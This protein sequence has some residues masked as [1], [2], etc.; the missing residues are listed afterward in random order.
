MRVLALL[1][2]ALFASAM[3]L[4]GQTQSIQ[5]EMKLLRVYQ[6]YPH[7]DPNGPDIT[8]KAR[9][10]I[11]G[12]GP[13]PIAG[14]TGQ[15]H[16]PNLQTV[17]WFDAGAQTIASGTMTYTAANT[18]NLCSDNISVNMELEG[19]EED[20][21]T[22]F[23][24]R[25]LCD[26]HRFGAAANG[27]GNARLAQGSGVTRVFQ[28]LNFSPNIQNR[29]YGFEVSLTYTLTN[30]IR[31]VVYAGNAQGGPVADVCEGGNYFVYARTGPGFSGGDFEFQRSDNN[32]A[33]W[34]TVQTGASPAY[35]VTA[36]ANPS[37]LYRVRLRGGFGCLGYANNEGWV[38]PAG[39]GN[40]RVIPTFNAAD[41]NYTIQS[42][43]EGDALSNIT[44][45]SINNLPPNTS[46]TMQLSAPD[47][48]FFVSP[49]PG[50]VS[51]PYTWQ[52]LEPG[53]YRLN[54][55]GVLINGE[56]LPTGQ[57]T[58]DIFIQ[59][60]PVT[61]PAFT[62]LIPA[63]PGC[64]ET[65][66]SV[67]AIISTYNAG[68]VH[69][70]Q[71]FAVGNTTT[72]VAT[73]NQQASSA[74]FSNLPPGDY[75]VRLTLNGTCVVN[76]GTFTIA[77]PPA[78]ASGTAQVVYPGAA[79]TVLCP[80]GKTTGNFSVAA[81]TGQNSVQ[82]YLATAL[83]NPLASG[84]ASPGSPFST[85][86]IPGNYT[87]VFQRAD[88]GCQEFE[89]FTIL[90]S[91]NALLVSVAATTKPPACTPLGG[92]LTL[93]V[94][95][96]T[97]PYTFKINGVVRT[98]TSTTGNNRLFNQLPSGRGIY[99]VTDA[100]GCNVGVQRF[101]V[102]AWV[103]GAPILE[104][105]PFVWPQNVVDVMTCNGGNDG[106]FWYEPVGGTGPFQAR[107]APL[108]AN[109][110]PAVAGTAPQIRENLP[111]GVY[112]VYMRDAANCE[113]AQVAYIEEFPAITIT[114]VVPAP[115]YCG[116]TH[117]T[118]KIYATGLLRRTIA[119][120]TW[121]QGINWSLN[122]A[123]GL[124]YSGSNMAED[125]A[126]PN[127]VIIT[128]NNISPQ[129]YQIIIR[130]QKGPA[131][132]SGGYA[133]A[134]AT[135]CFSPVFPLTAAD[136]NV[137]T[138]V[139]VTTQLVSPTCN[140]ETNGRITVNFT[141]GNPGYELT[142]VRFNSASPHPNPTVVET[143]VLASNAPGT[144]TFTNLP[145]GSYGVQVRTAIVDGGASNLPGS[146]T[147]YFPGNWNTSF[148]APYTLANP[149]A[150][151]INTISTVT[152]LQCDLTGGQITVQSV[153]GGT[154]PYRY[155]VNGVDFSTNNLLPALSQ[156]TVY[157]RD[158]N[159]CQA[160]RSY[161]VTAVV[162]P[163]LALSFAATPPANCG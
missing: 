100:N 145:P 106:Y 62:G 45:S 148:F 142:L 36:T 53:R 101:T 81:G 15:I 159:S 122:G 147:S 40:L 41:V 43:C 95:G 103:S 80:D 94:T 136:F 96:G 50:L 112:T 69:S 6:N 7:D 25:N 116:Q 67:T 18:F 161:A 57:C 157:V 27:V 28:L 89:N 125:P 120:L 118:M 131:Y 21:D 30:G 90:N 22:L 37:V 1:L 72:P 54:V 60:A 74:P 55:T 163:S 146:C 77:A 153:S 58:Q 162:N 48:P 114:K 39:A 143:V 35:R 9:A 137:P 2:P 127:G 78:S 141:G 130:Q 107:V 86:L 56:S 85:Q 13:N 92:T 109:Y 117:T 49:N 20:C 46:V 129:N 79:T 104:F 70:W 5:Y 3:A 128:M 140:G 126:D 47:D 14:P 51:L 12:L 110:G 71:V 82:V 24:F 158:A 151:S 65:T 16:L 73:G 124:W 133:P 38:T 102:P 160:T 26:G 150:I 113:T 8:W 121:Q 64:D 87:A 63:N 154:P 23:H 10:I 66:G 68:L 91:S 156:N 152:P 135:Q 98:P 4:Y 44:V 29:Y 139:A 11:N 111:P 84:T 119:G 155:S 76:S 105:R 134:Y 83:N 149:S 115:M 88:N 52:N 75:F 61:L 93:S 32:G 31:E 144:Y 123:D 59:I 17:G 99:E 34:T 108:D 138:P 42:S 19:W 97:P 132:A 33:T